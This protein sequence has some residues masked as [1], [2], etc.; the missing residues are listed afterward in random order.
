LCPLFLFLTVLLL[1]LFLLL[2]S[3]FQTP[4]VDCCC[5]F[6]LALEYK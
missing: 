4:E 1:L 6:W 2:S 5:M 3:R